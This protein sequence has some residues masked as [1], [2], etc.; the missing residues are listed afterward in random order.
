METNKLVPYSV[1]LHEEPGDTFPL[2]F[3]CMAE[4]DDHAAAQAGNAYPC[5]EILLCVR[6][7]PSAVEFYASEDFGP[8]CAQ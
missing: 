4:D 3:Y 5:C 6:G 8:E 2:R 1:S 7:D